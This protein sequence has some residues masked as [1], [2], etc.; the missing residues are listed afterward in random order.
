VQAGAFAAKVG[1]FVWLMMQARWTL[2]RFRYDQM[3]RLGWKIMLPLSLANLAL[4]ALLAY[5][6]KP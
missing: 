6:L 1:F 3:M 4:T 2:L 5:S